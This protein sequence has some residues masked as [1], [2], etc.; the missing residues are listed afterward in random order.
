MKPGESPNWFASRVPCMGKLN[1]KDCNLTK[2]MDL[3]AV[4]NLFS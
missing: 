3:P 2:I 4:A 1:M